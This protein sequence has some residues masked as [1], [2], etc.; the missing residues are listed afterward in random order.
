VALEVSA[1]KLGRNNTQLPGDT[2]ISK[3]VATSSTTQ[4][5]LP[6]R[7]MMDFKKLMGKAIM[8]GK[9]TIQIR[10]R[11]FTNADIANI[12]PSAGRVVSTNIGFSD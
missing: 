8:M 9:P 6:P 7:S 12:Q 11:F 10:G 1:D 3:R 4:A 5:T 2:P